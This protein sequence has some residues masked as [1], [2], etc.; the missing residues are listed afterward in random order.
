M[1]LYLVM[2]LFQTLSA[3]TFANEFL[4]TGLNLPYKAVVVVFCKYKVAEVSFPKS[5][6][7]ASVKDIP[8]IAEI[9][10][11]KFGALTPG[12]HIPVVSPEVLV[13]E[14]PDYILL[15][16]WNYRDFILEKEKVLRERGAK[17]II[18]IPNVEI[19]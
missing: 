10:E 13:G 16:A 2:I 17:F 11:D 7:L 15:L 12:S 19:V 6:F 5:I 18:P 9:N 1:L 3:P 8:F 14:T 4:I